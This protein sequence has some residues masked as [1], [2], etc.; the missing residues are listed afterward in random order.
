MEQS[1]I[2]RA[3]A[4][5]GGQ[6]KLAGLLTALAD[7]S[8]SVSPQAVYLWVKHKRVPAKR[9]LAIEAVTGIPR[10]ELRSDLYPLEPA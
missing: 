10:H 9:V 6:R 2:E 7:D 3:C 8:D 4:A 5:V 1:A